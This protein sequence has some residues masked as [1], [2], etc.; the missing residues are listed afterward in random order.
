MITKL[1][2]G[3]AT[4][5]AML[6]VCAISDG[7]KEGSLFKTSEV[8]Y[9]ADSG[10]TIKNGVLTSYTGSGG[11]VTIPDGVTSIGDEAFFGCSSLT[12]IIIPSG[13]TSIGEGAFGWCGSLTSITIPSSATSIG[14]SAFWYC[15]SLTSITI[16]SGVTSIGFLAFGYCSSLTSITIPSSVTSIGDS[17]FWYCSSLTIICPAGSTAET[18]AKDYG[19]ECNTEGLLAKP[20]I[21]SVSTASEKSVRITWNKVDN[22]DGYC[23]YRS[24]DNKTFSKIKTITS[25]STVSF[26]HSSASYTTDGKYYYYYKVVPYITISGKN[27]EGT[28]SAA[29]L[30]KYKYN[31][32]AFVEGLYESCLG[33]SSDASGYVNWC[34]RL[35]S[36]S[37]TAIEAAYGFVFSSEF[38]KKNYCNEDYV[39]LLYKAFLG[40]DPDAA[41]KKNWLTRMSSGMTREEVFNGFAT[42]NEFTALC[43]KYGITLGSK[44]AVPAYGTVPTGACSVCGTE[45]GV[46]QFVKRM[47][48]ECLGRTYDAT[49]LANWSNKLWAHTASGTSVAKGFFFSTEFT[50]KNLGNEEFVNRL[51]KALFGRNPDAG[52]KAKWLK[53]LNSGTSRLTVFE[54]FVN[55]DEFKKL[56]A[57]YG[58]VK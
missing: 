32:G 8:V 37:K 30:C 53:L 28:V 20:V 42:S 33:R 22:A 43:T 29:V 46:T 9:A 14:D 26:T 17:A 34:N 10:F 12:S 18:Y 41:G 57:S 4:V 13:V 1:I 36:K 19:I 55:S 2:V 21:S 39:I 52:G 38:K 6:A 54:G 51:Y 56:C 3:A 31:V 27:C 7:T 49:G 44:I 16:P 50:K 23:I 15:S 35:T 5:C 45:A 48:T 58:I 40:R 11:D 25:G 24:T 47:Y